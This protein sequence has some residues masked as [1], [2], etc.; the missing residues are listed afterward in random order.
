MSIKINLP[1]SLQPLAGDMKQAQVNGGTVG[2]CIKELVQRHPRLR[3]KLFDDRGKLL[4][5]INI[6]IN[7]EA[8]PAR[9]LSQTVRDG[10]VLH[11]F[12]PVLGG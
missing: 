8:V 7:N 4:N 9:V 5:S 1:P 3:E 11:I 12:I 10:D 6:S 2:D